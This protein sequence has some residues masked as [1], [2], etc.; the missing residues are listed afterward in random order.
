[1][2][3]VRER[4][5]RSDGMGR[6]GIPGRQTGTAH[7]VEPTL[8]IEDYDEAC[9]LNRCWPGFFTEEWTRGKREEQDTCSDKKQI[10]TGPVGTSF[11]DTVSR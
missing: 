1:M 3:L 4:S 10:L 9:F 6:I 11:Q 2:E 7:G 5:R 8:R